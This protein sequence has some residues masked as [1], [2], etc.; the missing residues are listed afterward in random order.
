MS[1]KVRVRRDGWFSIHRLM[2]SSAEL[3][4]SSWIK[5]SSPQPTPVYC[6]PRQL[7]LPPPSSPSRYEVV[8]QSCACLAV[9]NEVQ[10]SQEAAQQSDL[11]GTLQWQSCSGSD[12][13]HCY[14]HTHTHRAPNTSQEFKNPLTGTG[15][16]GLP[17]FFSTLGITKRGYGS[18]LS[19]LKRLTSIFTAHLCGCEY[20]SSWSCIN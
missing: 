1:E 20:N 8:F 3:G 5:L 11:H 6:L 13:G 17:A 7:S 18:K 10:Q 12:W 9:G 14:T 15:L 4:P 16:T 2:V 19:C